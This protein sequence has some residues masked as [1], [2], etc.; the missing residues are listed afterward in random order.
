MNLLGDSGSSEA[1]D[2]P[3]LDMNT[4][5]QGIPLRPLLRCESGPLI[6]ALRGPVLSFV[7]CSSLCNVETEAW[8]GAGLS[9]LRFLGVASA[10]PVPGTLWLLST[11][12]DACEGYSK[13][14]IFM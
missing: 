8:G 12:L 6:C 5:P 13:R 7:A 3:E 14:M 4:S 9:L 1:P 10:R 2:H 11:Y